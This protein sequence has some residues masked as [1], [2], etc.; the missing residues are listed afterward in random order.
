MNTC[1]DIGEVSGTRD[2]FTG[3]SL[4]HT[5]L[6]S[7]SCCPLSREGKVTSCPGLSR[8]P[9]GSQDGNFFL[10]LTFLFIFETGRDRA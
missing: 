4:S 3:S 10:F 9:G 8:N 2:G 1:D 5:L 6:M 7:A